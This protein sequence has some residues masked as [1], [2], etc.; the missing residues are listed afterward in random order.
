MPNP[1]EEKGAV[2]F[3]NTRPCESHTSQCSAPA[4]SPVFPQPNSIREAAEYVLDVMDA[5]LLRLMDEFRVATEDRR[6]Q[7]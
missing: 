6:G 5:S 4:S 1:K 2:P 3:E 7:W